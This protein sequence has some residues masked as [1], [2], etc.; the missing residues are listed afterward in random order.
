M[1]LWR[2]YL[3]MRIKPLAVFAVFGL[4]FLL[5]PAL[6]RLPSEPSLYAFAI[7]AFFGAPVLIFDFLSFANRYRALRRSLSDIVVT[8][9]HLPAPRD[10]LEEEYQA[11]VRSLGAA[12]T[13]ADAAGQKRYVE[14]IEYYTVWVHQIKTPIS[15]MYLRLQ[16]E[17]TALSRQLTEELRKIEQYVEMVLWYLRLDSDDTDYLIR[18]YDLDAIVKQAVRRFAAQFIHRKIALVYEPVEFRVL[19]D[20]KQLLFV[21]EQLIS[22]ALKYTKE[23][24]RVSIAMDEP[25][26]LCITDSGIGIAPEDLPR[27][28]ERGY[29]GLNGRSDKKASGIG[30]YLCKRICD[31]LGH[32]IKA[33]SAPGCGT[34]I[35]LNLRT[36]ALEIE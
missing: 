2:S 35:S 36:S 14:M 11:I 23:G 22:N 12:K 6:Y 26:V 16:G 33:M 19:T 1:V 17:D 9:E 10:L 31:N 3:K 24:G 30:L 5:V 4:V 18:E 27:V 29:T 21:L 8:T 32:G 28:F 34:A 15:A 13:A 25:G 20:E 7:C